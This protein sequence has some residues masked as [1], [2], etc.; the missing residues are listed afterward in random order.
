MAHTGKGAF[1]MDHGYE[2][3]DVMIEIKVKTMDSQT[4]NLRISNQRK[5]RNLKEDIT[6]LIGMP[7][8]QQCLIYCG[9]VLKDDQLI[10]SCSASHSMGTDGISLGTQ[11]NYCITVRLLQEITSAI[12]TLSRDSV[13][14]TEN[15][16][17]EVL[18]SAFNLPAPSQ[19]IPVEQLAR[20]MS[21][22][23]DMLI[24]E[25]SQFFLDFE[26]DLRHN[27]NLDDPRVHHETMRSIEILFNYLGTYF[28]ELGR[29]MMHVQIGEN[30]DEGSRLISSDLVSSGPSTAEPTSGHVSADEPASQDV[31]TS[32]QRTTDS[33]ESP[34]PAKQQRVLFFLEL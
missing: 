9:K 18:R 17:N 2:G 29:V 15:N 7:M 32:R 10:S 25:T 6:L 4:H 20:M 21:S 3:I 14:G 8:E 5:V 30:T 16:V 34:S 11:Q 1:T 22:T 13:N 28:C 23:R 27:L 33:A 12:E 31:G 26:E 19:G 24:N